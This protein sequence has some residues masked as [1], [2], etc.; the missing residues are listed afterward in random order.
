MVVL[1]AIG[2]FLIGALIS[3]GLM[4][5]RHNKSS[6]AA[7]NQISSLQNDISYARQ[8]TVDLEKELS[9]AKGEISA[10]H[11]RELKL[12]DDLSRSRTEYE[13]LNQRLKE[14]KQ[15]IAQL[16]EKFATEFKNLANQIFEE[17]SKK[18]TDQNKENLGELLNPLRERILEFQKKVEDTNTQSVQRNAALNEQL[19]N[20]KEL[21]QQITQEAKSLTLALRGDSKTQGGWGEMQLENILSKAGL[22]KD[23]HYI[24]E[25]NLKTEEG[26]NQRLDYI[27]N[28]PDGKHLILD[29]KVSLTAYSRYYDSEDEAEQQRFLKQHLDSINGHIRSLGD[30]NYQSLYEINPPDYVMMFIANEPA[31]TIALKEDPQLYEKALDRNIV[32][33]STTTLLATLRTISYIWKQDLQNKNA[34]EIARQAGALYDKFVSFSEDLMKLGNQLGTV[35]K[36]YTDSMKKL[37]DGTGNLVKRTEKLRELGAKTSKQADQR[38]LDRAD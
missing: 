27:I 30:R 12:T 38:L 24:K 10:Q 5:M 9:N 13:N 17:K 31:L 34:E 6:K 29:S 8:K 16:N 37:T 26:S 19:K 3:W 35:Q 28:L 36:T 33:V 4:L 15:E 21:N 14:Q 18:F 7:E 22:Q 25:K 32:L 2:G 11:A 1:F 20:L 23:I